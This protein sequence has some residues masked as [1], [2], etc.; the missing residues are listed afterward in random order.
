MRKVFKDIPLDEI[1]LRRFEK[2]SSTNLKELSRKF[3]ISIG[4]LQPGDGRD[5]I[6]NIFYDFIVAAKNKEYIEINDLIKKYSNFDG[7]TPNNI[8][9]HIKRLKDMKLIE[10]TTY[11][12]RITEFMPL[13]E[14]FNELL[15]DRYIMPILNRIDEYA[16]LID[17]IN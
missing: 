7:G 12:Y 13:K 17:K 9:R 8:R 6:S 5:I 1:K 4:L 3:L 10:R 2:P 15:I 11:G 14:L 16:D